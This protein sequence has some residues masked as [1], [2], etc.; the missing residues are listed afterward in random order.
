MLGVLRCT[1][2]LGRFLG[3]NCKGDGKVKT[4]PDIEQGDL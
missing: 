4:F 1:N 2:I 3:D